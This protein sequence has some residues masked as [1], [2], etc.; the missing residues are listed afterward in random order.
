VIQFAEVLEGVSCEW[1][2]VRRILDQL[3]GLKL[4][5]EISDL[6]ARLPTEP[7]VMGRLRELLAQSQAQKTPPEPA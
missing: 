1:D 7:E 4:Q 3:L 6:I 2:E 5:Q